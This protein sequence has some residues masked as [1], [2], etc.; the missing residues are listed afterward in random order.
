MLSLVG[1]EPNNWSPVAGLNGGDAIQANLLGAMSLLAEALSAEDYGSRILQIVSEVLAGILGS[2]AC[3]ILVLDEERREL[4]VAASQCASPDYLQSG[5]LKLDDT[6]VGLAALER[7]PVA[8]ANI[9]EDERYRRAELARQTGLVSLLAVPLIARGRV[10][11]VVSIYT[12]EH[13]VFSE[14]EIALATGLAAQAAV[15]LENARLMAELSE[16]KRTLEGRKLV[17]RAKG[18]LQRTQS[19]TEEEAYLRLRNESRRLRRPMRELAEAIILSED[20]RRRAR[21]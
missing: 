11:G 21:E 20:L 15:A 2:P 4:T 12:Q 14:E 18:I 5:P 7:R 3:S 9:L 1:E 19:I 16:M 13:R 6:A 10:T 8:I 17:E